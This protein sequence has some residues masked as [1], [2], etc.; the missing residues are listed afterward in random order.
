M[1]LTDQLLAARLLYGLPVLF[2]V[3]VMAAVGGPLPANLLFVAVGSFV[4]QGE[5]KMWPAIIVATVAAVLGDQIGYG[6]SRWAGRRLVA[7][8]SRKIGGEARIKKA[9][10]LAKRWGGSAIFIS[11]WTVTSLAIRPGPRRRTRRSPST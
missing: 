5:M 10:A 3:T 9:E 1:S 6:L 4:K 8:I 7:R 11:R 2:G